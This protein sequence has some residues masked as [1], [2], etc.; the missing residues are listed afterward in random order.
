LY[1]TQGVHRAVQLRPDA[2]ATIFGER[3]TSWRDFADRVARYAAGLGSLGIGAGERIYVIANNSDLYIET[4]YAI[5]WSGAVAVPG[6]Y[7]WSELEHAHAIQ[8]SGAR[9]LIVDP[10][11]ITLG[12]ALAKRCAIENVL[13]LTSPEKPDAEG[14]R[15]TQ[16]LIVAHQPMEDRSG[17]GDDLFAIFYTG[18]TTGRPKGVMLSNRNI[19][20][21]ILSVNAM[22]SFPPEPIFLHLPPMFHLADAGAIF[23]VTFFAG[24]H[25]VLPGF[26]P[27]A[28][29]ATIERERVNTALMVPTM[30]TMLRAQLDQQRADMSS[31]KRIRYGAAGIT[32]AVLRDAM[33]MFPNAEFQQGY[34][35]TEMSPAVTI[36]E[37]RFHEMIADNP[38]L[39][40]AGRPLIGTDVRIVDEAMVEKPRGEVGEIVASGPGVML[41][42]WNQPELTAAT[43]INGWVKTGDAGYMD[44][45][46]FVYIADRIKDMIVTGG[47]NVYSAE[48]ENALQSHP[49]IAECAVFGVPDE[50]WGERVHAIVRFNV[51]MSVTE[52]E[53]HQHC[54]ALIAAY[55]CPRSF[56][57][58][59][60]PLPLSAQ[61]KIT[62]AELR[63]PHWDGR[64]RQ[65]G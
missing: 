10:L 5:A 16:E 17:R 7:R 49:M 32:Q 45:D 14:L 15:T 54:R 12:L 56:E 11:H 41:G 21:N 39:R 31:M 23:T 58:W 2:L 26:D 28:V 9:I 29:A 35:Q 46:G 18:G 59:T 27:A 64:D 3:R 38:R 62:K 6:N 34:G 42:Y 65:V 37:P 1:I 36:L 50:K 61:G 20:S 8:E 43:I 60:R 40:S 51:G 13:V 53:L 19:V 25:V 52:E 4:Y 33:D 55:K 22:T 57:I 63:K 24:T 30:F 48:V 47:E 44:E